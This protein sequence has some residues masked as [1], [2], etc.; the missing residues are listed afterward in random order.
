MRFV[1][2]REALIKPLQLVAGVV[3][4][5]QTLPVLSNILLVAEG[6]QLSMTGTDLEV[7]L[8]GRVTLDEP[9]E[10]GSITVPARKLMDICKS[11]P[12]NAIIEVKLSDAKVVIKA[13]RTRFTLTTLPATEFP[14]VEDCDQSF[15]L[16]LPQEKLRHLIDQTGFSMAQ[17]D[18][19]YYLNG[20]MM[21]VSDG[22]LRSVSTDGHRLATSVTV[23]E[24]ANETSE[25]II[26]PRKGILEL[27]RLL[28][29]GDEPLKLVVGSNH[30][31]AHVAD[32]I[33][34][35]KL[36]DGKFPDYQRV[37]PRGGDKIVLGNRQEL[38]Q[39]FSRIAIL[40][41][42]KYRGVRLTLTSGFLKVMA[43][44]PEQEEAEE[45]IAIDYQG[46]S[47]EIGFNVN[48]LIDVL[49]IINSDIVRFTLSDSNSSALVESYDEEGS[50]FVV[51]PM[52]M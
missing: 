32:Y 33:F 47:L 13:G 43:N 9:A 28:Q 23:A 31:R 10:A 1:I 48:Y 4:R 50:V 3:E 5:R 51:M 40:S 45:T 14:N 38:R 44:N 30:I 21:E 39:V 15:E 26:I 25:Q 6:D 16:T 36:V 35:S 41:N 19:R 18:V 11:L 24:T 37:I 27:A 34:T 17:Q 29:G 52:R 49:S 12:D 46:E 20:M 2:S 7:E 8:V 22:M 42:E